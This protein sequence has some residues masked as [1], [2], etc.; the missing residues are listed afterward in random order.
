MKKPDRMFVIFYATAVATM[1]MAATALARAQAP[2]LAGR[3]VS[4]DGR[5]VAG[6][7]VRIGGTSMVTRSGADGA[8]AFAA[9]PKG[10]QVVQFH[11]VGYLPAQAEVRVPAVSDSTVV[12][13][14]RTPTELSTVRVT[15]SVNVLGGVVVDDRNQPIAGATVDL[16][17]SGVK[18]KSTGADG[19]FSFTGVRSGVALVR[20]RKDG[21]QPVVSSIELSDWRGL[22]LHMD[23]AN[24]G[25]TGA[26]LKDASGFGNASAFVWTE[27]AQRISTAGSLAITI[28]REELAPY[29]DMSL[30]DAIPRTKNGAIRSSD[31]LAAQN[32]ICVL[33]NGRTPVGSTSLNTY[34]TADV[35]FVEIYPPGTEKSGSAANYLRSTGCKRVTTPDS[36]ISGVFYAV[37]WLR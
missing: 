4:L 37:V 23:A 26:A 31:L 22:V 17:S 35:E 25:L 1:L 12:T 13:M 36:G 5:P 33:L 18:S 28:P 16:M 6:V 29:D 15:A 14:L 20:A 9:A 3:V 21:Y 11:L 2:N 10:P 30:G 19:W 8:Y 34:R 32:S 24:A 7:E 27:T